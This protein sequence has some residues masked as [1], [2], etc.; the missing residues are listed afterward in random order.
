MVEKQQQKDTRKKAVKYN[1]GPQTKL[2]VRVCGGVTDLQIAGLRSC[3][4]AALPSSSLEG[5]VSVSETD[6]TMHLI[7]YLSTMFST[8]HHHYQGLC[9]L[10]PTM[11]FSIAI[12]CFLTKFANSSFSDF[13]ECAVSSNLCPS[14]NGQTMSYC[15]TLHFCNSFA[16]TTSDQKIL[17]PGNHNSCH[18]ARAMRS[19]LFLLEHDRRL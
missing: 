17:P 19:S 5:G 8:F 9:K 13:Q 11:R 4:H 10:P 6:E 16:R 3:V 12:G 1:R 14:S 7:Q 18:R 2:K 15:R